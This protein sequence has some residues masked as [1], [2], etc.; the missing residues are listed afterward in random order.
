VATVQPHSRVAGAREPSKAS[1]GSR[2]AA[3]GATQGRTHDAQQ[4]SHL[5]SYQDV[6]NGDEITIPGD[7]SGTQIHVGD[8]TG[9]VDQLS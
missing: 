3:A 5:T 9:N 1:P 2:Q 8:P 6:P 7:T 4:G